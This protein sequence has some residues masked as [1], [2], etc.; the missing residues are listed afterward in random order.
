[1][2][3]RKSFQGTLTLLI[4]AI[5]FVAGSASAQTKKKKK[6]TA[7][8][9][10]AA[11]PAPTTNGDA[12]VVSLAD[13][14]QNSSSQIIQ[15]NATPSLAATETPLPDDTAQRLKELQS[16]IKKLETSQKSEKST[17][18]EKQKAL[19]TNLDILTKAEQ[20]TESLRRQRFELIEKENSI[21]A[22]LDQIEIDIRPEAIERTIAIVG[23]LRPEEL[24]EARRK[25][26]DAE[27]RNLQNLLNDIVAART[28]LDQ[29][30]VRSDALVEKLRA[31]LE[32]DIDDAL[33]SDEPE[34]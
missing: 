1:M 31:K 7:K 27:R 33:N 23:S 17:Y 11:K 18:E 26:L 16:R 3:C 21:R 34:Q 6:R 4:C 10:V 14:Y 32:K 12:A 9:P 2:K 5:V 28:R 29:D 8:R 19:L 20:R 13:Q 25:S 24:R 15:P 22:R 30:V